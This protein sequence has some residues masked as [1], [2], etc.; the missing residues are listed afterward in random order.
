MLNDIHGTT[1]RC[2]SVRIWAKPI[3]GIALL[4][5]KRSKK[6]A[7]VE[8]RCVWIMSTWITN[9]LFSL[10]GSCWFSPCCLCSYRRVAELRGK[11]RE[12]N[13]EVL[14]G[15]PCLYF[16]LLPL[17]THSALSHQP[18]NLIRDKSIPQ[19]PEGAGVHSSVSRIRLL[20][21]LRGYLLWD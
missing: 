10:C 21:K 14:W 15:D 4:E 11:Y 7:Y 8:G 17:T 2:H 1:S 12:L 13:T 16:K 5:G 3:R 19:D 9:V 6:T 20:V 18:E